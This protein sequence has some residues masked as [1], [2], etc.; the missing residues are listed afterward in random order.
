M[1]KA[2][3]PYVEKKISQDEYMKAFTEA[4]YR[5]ITQALP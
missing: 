5:E 4:E 3:T 2:Y 1:E